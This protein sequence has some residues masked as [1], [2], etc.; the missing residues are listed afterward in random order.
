MGNVDKKWLLA[1]GWMDG[2]LVASNMWGPRTSR[3]RS[4]LHEPLDRLD[5]SSKLE[6]RARRLS[7]YSD[8]V[9]EWK[10]VS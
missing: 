4:L 3:V 10:C 8:I 9:T 2:W 6:N 5:R 1:D 7:E